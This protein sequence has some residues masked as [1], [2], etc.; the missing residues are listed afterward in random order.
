MEARTV[1]SVMPL[2]AQHLDLAGRGGPAVAPH[3]GDHEGLRARIA[4]RG[5][6]FA[7]RGREVRNAAAAAGDGDLLAGADGG[8]EGCD[9]AAGGGSATSAS[10]GRSKFWRTRI[11]AGRS[12]ADMPDWRS[13]SPN[14]R[15]RATGVLLKSG[16]PKGAAIRPV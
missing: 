9:L 8:K 11:R 6:G 3:A 4:D 16:A 13:S 1:S 14:V 2:L 12:P 7:H 5:R 10:R 15:R